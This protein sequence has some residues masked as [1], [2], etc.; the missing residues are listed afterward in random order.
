MKPK[1]VFLFAFAND[2]AASLRLDEEWRQADRA[3]QADEDAGRLKYA[4]IPYATRDDVW[5]K[6]NRFHNQITIFH[7]GGHSGSEGLNLGDSVLE[8]KNLATLL[9]QEQNL[10]LVFLNGCSNAGQVEALLEKGVPAVIAT[11]API[12]DRR[13]VNLARQFYTALCS[14]RSIKEAFSTAAAYVN[15]EEKELLVG[16]RGTRFEEGQEQFEWGLYAREEVVLDWKIPKEK[17]SGQK[18]GLP[19]LPARLRRLLGIILGTLLLFLGYKLLWPAPEIALDCSAGRRTAVFVA[20]FQQAGADNFASNVITELRAGLDDGSYR[21]GEAGFQGINISDY[22]DTIRVQ[23]FEQSCDTSGL[24]LGGLWDKRDSLLNCYINLYSLAVK[25]PELSGADKIILSNPPGLAFSVREDSRFLADFVIALLK[26]YEGQPYE[27][28]KK[29]YELEKDTVKLQDPVLKAYMAH[30][31]GNCYAMRGD[32]VRA[33]KSYLEAAGLLPA[34][35]GEA[36]RANIVVAGQI[37][38]IMR[39]EPELEAILKNNIA[40][41]SMLETSLPGQPAAGPLGEESQSEK[42]SIEVVAEELR[43]R[44][45]DTAQPAKEDSINTPP[46]QKRNEELASPDKEEKENTSPKVAYGKYT[47]PRDN[48]TYKTIFLNGKTWLAENLNYETPD[49]YCYDDDP[50]KCREYGRLYIWQAAKDACKRLGPRWRLPTD[51]E[52][53]VLAMKFGGYYDWPA[54][55]AVGDPQKSYKAL[56]EGGS[57]GFSALL[58]GWLNADGSFFYLLDDYGYYWSA[59]ESSSGNAWAYNFYSHNGLLNRDSNDKGLGF[60]CRCVQD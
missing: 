44:A 4:I 24:F 47:D 58:G 29:F 19:G 43:S 3:L 51:D 20:P 52:W 23:Y 50:A 9:E 57:S 13:A 10:K 31:K 45:G 42:E 12:N 1:P 15:N 55:K 53:R 26:V 35:L 30:Y 34:K 41:D 5:D 46:N 39:T 56:L 37:A 17:T 33:E 38:E 18:R 25:I 22:Y 32:Q 16:Y 59:T 21:V 60:S 2:I 28:L 8:G 49:S 27:A 6:F 7:Y 11:S 14:G 54:S 40:Q 48:R 36:A